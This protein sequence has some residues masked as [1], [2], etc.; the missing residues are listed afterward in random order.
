[1]S[2]Y[3]ENYKKTTDGYNKILLCIDTTIVTQQLKCVPNMVDNWCNLVELYCKQVAQDRKDRHRKKNAGN[4]AEAAKWM[5][6]NLK[7]HYNYTLQSLSPEEYEGTFS[8]AKVKN[9][10]EMVNSTGDNHIM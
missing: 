8:P 5:F 4:L 2:K 6:E 7:E 1:M 9:I 10:Q 3:S